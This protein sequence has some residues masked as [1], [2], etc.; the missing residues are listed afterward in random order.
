MGRP[1]I[2]KIAMTSA[3]RVRRH[4][5][6]HCPEPVTKPVTKRGTVDVEALVARIRELEGE[7][8]R[9]R[10]RRAAAEA[11]ANAPGTAAEVAVLRQELAANARISE[12]EAKL[13]RRA[14]EDWRGGTAVKKGERAA[15]M[16]ARAAAGPAQEGRGI[17][18]D[19]RDAELGAAIR[20]AKQQREARAHAIR[21]KRMSR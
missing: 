8:A 1:P 17:A 16:A 5:L 3:E 18:C 13:A 11:V 7:L 9:E 21:L 19:A 12:L 4:R 20:A 15:A 2:G 14:W 10:K 6:K